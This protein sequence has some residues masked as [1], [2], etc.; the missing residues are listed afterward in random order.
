MSRF[1]LSKFKA[2]DKVMA[3][4]GECV[5]ED[6]RYINAEFWYYVT[7]YKGCYRQ[8]ELKKTE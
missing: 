3:P 1:K 5:V 4:H 6:V 7:K 8:S 2:G